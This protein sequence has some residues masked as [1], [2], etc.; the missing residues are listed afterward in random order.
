MKANLLTFDPGKITGYSVWHNGTVLQAG[1]IVTMQEML[2]IMQKWGFAHCC[3][4]E[5]FARANA[6][7]G[8][9]LQAIEMC[10]AI[11]AVALLYGMKLVKQYPS[12]RVGYLPYA[13]N[14]A[15]TLNIERAYL[16][17]AIDAIAH[18]LRYL[19][20]EGFEWQMQP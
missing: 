3:V 6:S 17:H 8:D 13:K 9:Q 5:G 14:H 16:T 10:G 2:M 20:K 15:A 7:T 12:Q 19:D 1:G 18:G 4:Y 11:Q